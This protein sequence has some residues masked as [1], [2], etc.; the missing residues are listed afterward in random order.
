MTFKTEVINSSFPI[1]KACRVAKSS[2]N[3]GQHLNIKQN[4]KFTHFAPF[5]LVWPLNTETTCRSISCTQV[6]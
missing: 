6:E 1:L 2:S 3:T 5:L 4:I